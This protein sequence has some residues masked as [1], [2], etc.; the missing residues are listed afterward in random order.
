MILLG[1]IS[2]GFPGGSDI[3]ESAW[4]AEDP[5]LTPGSEDPLEKGMATDFSILA[6]RVPWS[7]QFGRQVFSLLDFPLASPSGTPITCKLAFCMLSHRSLYVAFTFF[8]FVYICFSV[9]CSNIL[10]IT[11][12]FFCVIYL[13]IIVSKLV[14]ISA[15]ELSKLDWFVFMVLFLITVAC[16]SF[17]NLS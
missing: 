15:V 2:W 16:T 10:Q 6:Q 11:Y 1:R 8:C 5:G 14:F 3:K 4:N 12:S 7:E 9:C 13:L 17:D